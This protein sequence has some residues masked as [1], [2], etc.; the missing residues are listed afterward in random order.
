MS[1]IS[2]QPD[3]V[4]LYE[5]NV[6]I[7]KGTSFDKIFMTGSTQVVLTNIKIY[8]VTVTK[9]MFAKEQVT[10]DAHDI[11]EIKVYNGVPQIKQIKANS[12]EVILNLLSCE[13]EMSFSSRLEAHKFVNA[14]YGL[15]TGKSTAERGA[16][17]L[18]GAVDMVNDTLGIDTVGTVKNVLE[19]GI[20]RTVFGGLGKKKSVNT[21]SLL[22]EAVGISK[23][24]L[25]QNQAQPESPKQLTDHSSDDQLETL[26]K[27]KDLLDAGILTQ[28]EFDAKKK[29]ILKL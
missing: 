2:L 8:F 28:E 25:N 9:K 4:N 5:G 1:H 18:K 27:L 10:V 6:S 14:V 12:N 19:N 15:V 29:Q 24:L 17:K 26:K 7:A 11:S 20:T 13:V 16:E 3:E 21:H 23:A 22:G